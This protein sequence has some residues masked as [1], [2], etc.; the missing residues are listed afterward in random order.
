MLAA[1]TASSSGNVVE[2]LAT[3]SRDQMALCDARISQVSDFTAC[4]VLSS[5]RT[6][7]RRFSGGI[8]PVAWR[9][10]HLMGNS[11]SRQHHQR[12]TSKPSLPAIR[13]LLNGLPQIP[14]HELRVPID[15][16]QGA[17]HDVRE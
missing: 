2:A 11:T 14:A 6:G 5:L 3:P 8:S 15:P 13:T 12:S 9:N 10:V 16:I 1:K 7:G 17:R 4:R